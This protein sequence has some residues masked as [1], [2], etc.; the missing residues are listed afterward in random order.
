MRH[1]EISR[2]LSAAG[3]IRQGHFELSS[4]LHSGTYVQCALV[5]QYPR[6]AEMLGRA[7]ATEFHDLRVDCV[8]S[9]AL[10]GIILGQEVARALSAA[11]SGAD[12]SSFAAGSAGAA[13][14]V[15]NAG[16]RAIFVERDALGTLVLRRGFQVEQGEH[17]LVVEDVWTT[18]GSTFETMRVI[19]QSGGR[20][21]AVGALIDRSGGQIE[22]PVRAEALLD[23]KVGSYEADD[24][25]LCRSGSAV[26]RPGSRFQRQK[27]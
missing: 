6:Y 14:I 21:I 10:G 22:F 27:L 5:L 24:C 1:E 11:R 4:G 18:G 13:G 15:A 3:A 25:P 7:L 12:G 2:L 16:T 9:P 17:V 23:L 20:V 26:T 8:A 19:E